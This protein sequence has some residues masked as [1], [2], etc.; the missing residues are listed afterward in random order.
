MT[1]GNASSNKTIGMK[2]YKVILRVLNIQ[3]AG[4]MAQDRVKW[5]FSIN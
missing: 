4:D 1:S 5:K 3:R 2:L